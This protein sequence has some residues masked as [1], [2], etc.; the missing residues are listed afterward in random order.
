MTIEI[1]TSDKIDFSV[2]ERRQYN[3]IKDAM[4]EK[5]SKAESRYCIVVDYIIGSKQYD[6][7]IIKEDAIISIDLKG[8]KGTVM[9]SEYGDWYVEKDDGE[10]I[11]IAQRKNPFIQAR[12]QRYT[13]IE[14]LNEK[15]PLISK[16]FH[17]K[18]IFN[19]SAILCFEGG[20]TYNIE[21]IDC[22]SNPWFDVT[23]ESHI[24]EVIEN[25]TSNE[26][27]LKNIEIDALLK[28][29][30][31]QKLD[32]ERQK[33]KLDISSKSVLSSEDIE[34]I[35]NRVV[36]DFGSNEFSYDELSKLAD[37]EVTARYLQE[38]LEKK[39]VEKNI[40]TNKFFLAEN[41]SD[42]LPTIRADED[43]CS[44][45]DIDKYSEADFW[46]RPKTS[47]SGKEYKGVYRGTVYHMNSRGDVW[48]KTGRSSP[49]IKVAFSDKKII[50]DLLA[51]KPQGGN[52]RITE[53]KEVLTKVYY[54][55]RGYV[56]I[57]VCQFDGDIELE[58]FNWQP[59]GM[60][61]GCLWPSIY[62]GT[63][64][65]VNNNGGLLIHIGENKVY[66]KE[67][68]E[69]LTKKIL[70]F[71]GKYGGGRF[72]INENGD[73]I[74]LIYTA[75]YPDK[76]KK[77]LEQLSPEEKNLIDIRKK[78]EGDQRVPIYVGKFKGNI[79]FQK[80]FDIH[81][82]WTEE[83]DEEFLKRLGV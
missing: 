19:I 50:D 48:W 10:K 20:S 15:L 40:V 64:F 77:Q 79:L 7:I 12:E 22:R 73:V 35:T 25:T 29:M 46:L 30:H 2:N 66:A 37:S 61:K 34:R 52:F 51:I 63:T 13:L 32:M 28:E 47:E 21:Q 55:D 57:Y 16:R 49:K 14:M 70:G 53:A 58:D 26:F 56:S 44:S 36:E 75:P 3:R 38:A 68:H 23:D 65:S 4:I 11:V 24:L 54:E 71:T 82:E 80:M 60:K 8:Y 5:L 43:I 18:E 59:E 1:F 33:E 69:E 78:T 41:W 42:H 67:G 76:I 83:D 17:E 31:L 74:V 6:I 9:G 45:D 81:R 27:R 72:K 62:D 39:I